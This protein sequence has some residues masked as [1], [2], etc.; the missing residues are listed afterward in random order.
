MK[1]RYIGDM[2]SITFRSVEF[3]KDEV[4]DLSDN[5]ELFKKVSVLD[6]FEVVSEEVDPK[7]TVKR[8]RRKKNEDPADLFELGID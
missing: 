6:F 2:E 1:V 7:I 8:T 5:P 4:V 3:P